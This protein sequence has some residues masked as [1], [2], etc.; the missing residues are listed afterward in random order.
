MRD[1]SAG[2]LYVGL[3]FAVEPDAV[4]AAEIAR[5]PGPERLAASGRV[6]RVEVLIDGRRGVAVAFDRHQFVAVEGSTGG[7][8]VPPTNDQDVGTPSGTRL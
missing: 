6:T 3:D 4:L 5:C 1:V 8:D 7:A 2:G